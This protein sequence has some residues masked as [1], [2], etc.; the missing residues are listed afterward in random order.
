MTSDRWAAWLLENRHGGDETTR[1]RQQPMLAEFRDRVLDRADLKPGDIALDVGCG[2]G[3]LGLETLRLLNGGHFQIPLRT[4]AARAMSPIRQG[5][6]VI[7]LSARQR[8]FSSAAVRSP[9]ARSPRS[10]AL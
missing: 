10:R 8:S 7:R 2:D 3:L 5:L 1:E 6:N 4:S 9:R